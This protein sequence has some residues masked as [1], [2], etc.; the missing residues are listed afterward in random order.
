MIFILLAAVVCTIA[1]ALNKL[2]LWVA[3][4]LLCLY[5]AAKFA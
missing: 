5:E 2:P 1:S 4:I 3:V